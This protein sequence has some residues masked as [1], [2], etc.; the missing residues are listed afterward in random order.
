MGGLQGERT[1]YARK[2][3]A[4]E[5]IRVLEGLVA[6]HREMSKYFGLQDVD[7]EH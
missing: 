7:A 5:C 3:N 2:G 6:V 4:L 1:R